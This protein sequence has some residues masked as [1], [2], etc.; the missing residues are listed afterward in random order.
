MENFPGLL[1]KLGNSKMSYSA[2]DTA[3]VA[4]LDEFD[5]IMSNQALEWLSRNQNPNGSWGSERPM[6][7]HD[8]VICTLSAMVALTHRGRRSR[9]KLQIEKGL[10]ALEEIIAGATRSLMNDRSGETAGFESIVPTL[11]AEAEQLGIIKQQK[12]H[13][14]GRLSQIRAAKLAKLTGHKISRFTSTSYL[15]EMVGKDRID[16]LDIDNLQEMNYSIGTSPSAT[17]HFALY[18]KPGDEKALNY[19]R[20]L[21]KAGDGGVAT[22]APHEIFERV[23]TLWN[24]SLTGLHK[25]DN[26]I[27]ALCAPHLDYLENH[28]QPGRGLSFSES[29]TTCDGDD[30]SVGFE[31]LSKFGRKPDIETVLSYEEENWFRCYAIERNPSV[32]ANVDFLGA[33]REAGYDKNHP[34]IKKIIKFI[35]SMRRPDGYWLDKWN[36]SPYYTTTR[37]IILCKGY[38]DE[39]CQESVDWML[40]RQE[41]NGSWGSYG[42]QSAEE[43][44]YCIQALKT[45]QMYRGNIPKDALEKACL[46]LSTHREPPYPPLWIAKTLYCTQNLVQ[47]S[48]ISA[49]ILAEM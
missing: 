44:A 21:V 11:V 3:W 17:A 38:D 7:Y 9:D 13:L 39:L 12:E 22:F 19:L 42:F 5:P 1:R 32:D 36:I 15:T 47:S 34:S 43:T 4:R 41:A 29:F 23:W 26:E 18:V 8:R 16:L 49:L 10:K 33:L 24:L 35:R 48:I 27:K 6:Y 30:T 28:W 46:W 37:V 14:L 2:Y 25:T 40:S 45:W 31:V 20:G